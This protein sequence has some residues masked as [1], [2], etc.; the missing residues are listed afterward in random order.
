VCT[1]IGD[2]ATS[3]GDFYEGINLG[4]CAQAPLVV[5]CINNAGHL[6][7]TTEQTAAESFAAKGTAAGIPGVRVDGNDVLA[8]GAA[9]RDAR[10]RAAAGEG[11]TLI[12]L[13]TTG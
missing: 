4:G 1:F 2:G 8:G 10:R 5:A 12:E 3:E 9:T 7:P 6:H 11:P 13:V